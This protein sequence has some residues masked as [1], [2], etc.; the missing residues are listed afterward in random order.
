[1]PR[2]LR[3]LRADLLKAGFYL[4][5]Q[6]GSHQIWKHPQRRDVRFNLA[7]PDGKDAKRYQEQ[8]LSVVLAQVVSGDSEET[9]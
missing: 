4:H 3:E 1:M 2:K 7:G 9:R 6:S 8:E 5:R